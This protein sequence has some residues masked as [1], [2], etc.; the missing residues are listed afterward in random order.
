MTLKN[1]QNIKVLEARKEDLPAIKVLLDSVN[2]PLPGVE[3]HFDNFI[4]LKTENVLRGTV[5]LEIYNDKALLRSFAVAGAH[6]GQ[7]FGQKLY[8]PLL[9]R[10][11]STVSGKSIF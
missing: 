2:L 5:G 8:L 3:D 7:G 10:Q 1:T 9:I 6:Q 4:L 11:E